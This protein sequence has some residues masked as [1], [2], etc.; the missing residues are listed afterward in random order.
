MTDSPSLPVSIICLPVC[1]RFPDR[2]S[3]A[4]K[5]TGTPAKQPKEPASSQQAKEPAVAIAPKEP[6]LSLGREPGPSLSSKSLL[7]SDARLVRR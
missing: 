2:D 6:Q 1:V 3:P 5:A 7:K 4:P